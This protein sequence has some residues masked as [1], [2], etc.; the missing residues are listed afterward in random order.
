MLVLLQFRLIYLVDE[1]SSVSVYLR[2][3][4]DVLFWHHAVLFLVVLSAGF[5][6]FYS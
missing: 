5:V 6:S 4:P 2:Y 1:C 3:R